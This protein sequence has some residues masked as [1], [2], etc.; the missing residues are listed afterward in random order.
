MCVSIERLLVYD[1]K[2]NR[3]CDNIQRAHKSNNIM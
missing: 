2:H 1:I 3:W